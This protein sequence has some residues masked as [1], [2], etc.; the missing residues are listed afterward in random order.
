MH[1]GLLILLNFQLDLATDPARN[2]R[3][4]TRPP[5]IAERLA[6]RLESSL[7]GKK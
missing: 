7:P 4:I 2:Q 5:K 6:D 3:V 1:L